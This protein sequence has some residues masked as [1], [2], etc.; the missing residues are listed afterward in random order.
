MIKFDFSPE[1][2]F[3]LRKVPSY[4]VKLRAEFLSLAS[5][6][7][8]EMSDKISFWYSLD[9]YKP[10]NSEI[11]TYEYHYGVVGTQDVVSYPP[12]EVDSYD[13]ISTIIAIPDRMFEKCEIDLFILND[14]ATVRKLNNAIDKWS[15]QYIEKFYSQ[16]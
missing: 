10:L 14:I 3:F 6:N 7:T 11:F 4:P 8:N 2:V 16:K 13:K 15:K 9:C 5:K 1:K 12:T